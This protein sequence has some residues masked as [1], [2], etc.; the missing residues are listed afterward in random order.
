MNKKHREA[1]RELRAWCEKY[2]AEISSDAIMIDEQNYTIKWGLFN[3]T[4][5]ILQT[6]I[7]HSISSE[8]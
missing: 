3:N 7:N 1:F 5:E 2:D 4:T 8:G 6:F